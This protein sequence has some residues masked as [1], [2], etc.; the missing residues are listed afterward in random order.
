[1]L[2]LFSFF[3]SLSFIAGIAPME[4]ARITV[5]H[6]HEPQARQGHGCFHQAS[7]WQALQSLLPPRAV[8]H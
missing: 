8:L 6:K 5:F 7:V 3:L 1:M 4:S 2:S